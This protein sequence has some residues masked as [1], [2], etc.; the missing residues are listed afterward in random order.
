MKKQQSQEFKDALDMRRFW[1]RYN[2]QPMSFYQGTE[3]D[4]IERCNMKDSKLANLKRLALAEGLVEVEANPETIEDDYNMINDFISKHVY[5][6]PTKCK[7]CSQLMMGYSE[8][9]RHDWLYSV[10]QEEK[11]R[12]EYYELQ[13]KMRHE[14]ESRNKLYPV[15][16]YCDKIRCIEHEDISRTFEQ[17]KTLPDLNK[18]YRN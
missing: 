7:E 15:L 12:H 4:Y 10:C 8:I 13:S 6:Y 14:L 9:I 16:V 5:G 17:D 11:N 3:E 2:Q 1:S 18:Q